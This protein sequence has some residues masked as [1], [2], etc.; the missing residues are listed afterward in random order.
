MLKRMLCLLLVCVLL[1]G[2]TVTPAAQETTEPTRTET[3]AQ[4]LDRT[5][6]PKGFGLAYVPE[7]GFNPYDCV[8]ITNRPVLSLVYESL[9]V[10]NNSYQPEPVLCERF[11]V[12][13][14][15]KN[16]LVTLCEGVTFSDG[17]AL[18]AG[19]VVASLNA[20]RD[21]AFYGS[22]FSNVEA[23]SARDERTLEISLSQAYEN[24]PQLLD[25]PIVKSGTQTESAS[26]CGAT[27]A[28]G[29]TGL[30]LWSTRLSP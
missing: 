23:F 11:A 24:L 27:G 9:F 15:G 18:T 22:R 17:S 10:L 16:Y 8:C 28:G 1:T 13:E 14:D 26:R 19:D 12:S 6:K 21:S 5:T 20:A 4:S 3:Q 2:C 7:Y 30:R 29:R 25:V